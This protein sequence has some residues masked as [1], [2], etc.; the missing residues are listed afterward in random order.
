M[1]WS[2]PALPTALAIA[3]LEGARSGRGRRRLSDNRSARSTGH[4]WV[5]DD[6]SSN[7]SGRKGIA[8]RDHGGRCGTRLDRVASRESV[9]V[10]SLNTFVD[11]R[12]HCAA[13]HLSIVLDGESAAAVRVATDV[14]ALVHGALESITL[15]PEDV[16]GML[17]IPSRITHGEHEG[18]TRAGPLAVELTGI[19]DDLEEEDGHSDRM[20]RRAR[21]DMEEETVSANVA[22]GIGHVGGVVGWVKVLAVP[23]R[24]EED[25]RADAT[26]AFA[27][28]KGN[29]VTTAR[30]GVGV[31]VIALE[32]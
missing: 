9:E 19:P 8:V 22:G 23:A 25:V 16:V 13:I 2:S 11:D 10:G 6:R 20:G 5:R 18:L 24:R 27:S 17:S 32:V 26:V 3:S 15:P 21:S 1:S 28:R 7:T 31:L 30:I 14:C 29:C 12:V 4:G